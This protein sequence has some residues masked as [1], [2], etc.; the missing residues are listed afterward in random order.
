MS[1]PRL[2]AVLPIQG[3]IAENTKINS[4]K[5][6][7]VV[8]GSGANKY[9][10]Y[11]LE[12]EH[13][14]LFELVPSGNNAQL[15]LKA[16]IELDYETLS[17]LQVSI[18]ATSTQ[19]PHDPGISTSFTLRITDVEEAPVITSHGGLAHAIVEVSFTQV[20]AVLTTVHAADDD[21]DPLYFSIVG[22]ADRNL[23]QIDAQGNLSFRQVPPEGRTS[24]DVIV[25]VADGVAAPPATGILAVL[26][27][28]FP[29]LY[30]KQVPPL[31]DT[32]RLTIE[33]S[34]PNDAPVFD[35]PTR[36]L[37]GSYESLLIEG[38]IHATDP[39]GD[40]LTYR[41]LN[42][43]EDDSAL[44]VITEDGTLSFK[45]QQRSGSYHVVVEVSDGRATATQSV[46][47]ELPY[48]AP[49]LVRG[50]FDITQTSF[51]FEAMDLDGDELTVWYRNEQQEVTRNEDGSMTLTVVPGQEFEWGQVTV[52]DGLN[53][54]HVTNL[55]KTTDQSDAVA[56]L[57][58]D[59]TLL[60][61]FGG[62]D[63]LESLSNNNVLLGGEGDDVIYNEG[64]NN[65]LRGGSGDDSYFLFATND[66]SI[67][68]EEPNE[69][70]D[71]INF[72]ANIEFVAIDNVE[73]YTFFNGSSSQITFSGDD[74]VRAEQSVEIG[75]G[76]TA[77]IILD[78]KEFNANTSAPLTITG[79]KS[80]SDGDKLIL[81]DVTN[82]NVSYSGLDSLDFNDGV[83]SGDGSALVYVGS[84]R[85]FSI[86]DYS[87]FDST[88]EGLRDKLGNVMGVFNAG[89]QEV[90]LLI[91][92]GTGNVGV[93]E[94]D[95]PA[96]VE[97]TGDNISLEH[98]ATL[99]GVDILS[100][101]ALNFF[102]GQPV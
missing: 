23:F 100:L 18:R 32:Q 69:G 87:Q 34:K 83:L 42:N 44:F 8:A 62:S 65:V 3:S 5:V 28:R 85:T 88:V 12:G 17:S 19:K 64:S 82:N 80:G 86:L 45:E 20:N 11:K 93:F 21:G 47:V 33:L 38:T 22:G 90:I 46:T 91:Q 67:I 6:V 66:N 13:A 37:S 60:Y 59:G 35:T 14:N 84:Y 51:S 50:P 57:Q 71:K 95:F 53:T 61:T 72:Y 68:E 7:G 1:I 54:V 56:Q 40:A 31:T 99:V 49:E 10:K 78:N 41:I 76:S 97:L 63:T 29:D 58:D 74:S 89:W 25:S 92:D 39:N 30:S 101:N 26:Q 98:V 4:A 36:T 75:E 15:K 16:G 55:L 79:F 96:D 48:T 27:A 77:T 94:T 70:L 73:K 43:D 2:L 102:E 81:T 24:F 9:T 52:S